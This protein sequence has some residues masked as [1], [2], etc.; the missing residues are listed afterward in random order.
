VGHVAVSVNVMLHSSFCHSG[1]RK[2]FNW[3]GSNPATH[4]KRVDAFDDKASD[5]VYVPDMKDKAVSKTPR[6]QQGTKTTRWLFQTI[7]HENSVAIILSTNCVF[8]FV[9]FVNNL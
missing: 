7:N 2:M 6:E 8:S 3:I 9:R 4:I 1:R 5:N